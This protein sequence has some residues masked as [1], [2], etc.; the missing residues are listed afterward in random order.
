MEIEGDLY[1]PWAESL[2]PQ[3]GDSAC[4]RSRSL[5]N[6]IL[7]PPE[8]PLLRNVGFKLGDWIDKILIKEQQVK[9]DR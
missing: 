2:I 4:A 8:R 1:V 9:G 6:M 7:C 3:N 5:V